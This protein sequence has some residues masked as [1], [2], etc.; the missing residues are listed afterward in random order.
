M[1]KCPFCAEEIQDAAIVCRYCGRDLAAAPANASPAVMSGGDQSR[2]QKVSDAFACPSCG[3]TVRAG[4]T[5]C[6]HCGTALTGG[7]S[8]NVPHSNSDVNLVAMLFI[9]VIG[10]TALAVFMASS[11]SKPWTPASAADVK[12]AATATSPPPTPPAPAIPPDKWTYSTT[13]D[14]MSSEHTRHARILSENTVQFGFPYSGEQRASLSLLHHSSDGLNIQVSIER[15]QILCDVNDCLV[16]VRF[17]D[18]APTR[19]SASGSTLYSTTIFVE[20][21]QRFVAAVR[22]AK[23][24]RIELFFYQ[25]GSHTLEF[26]VAGFDFGRLSKGV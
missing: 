22:R 15:G 18:A 12:P 5:N 1:R 13:Y 10:L 26:D 23:T 6:S 2:G 21:E 19:F 20:N 24:V 14:Q 11:L 3:K 16:R 9:F 7:S 8:V 25:E 4:D 17:D